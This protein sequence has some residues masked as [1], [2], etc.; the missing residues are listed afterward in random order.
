[1]VAAFHRPCFLC[2]ATL[3][4]AGCLPTGSLRI[5]Q[6]T[7]TGD[8]VGKQEIIRAMPER[9]NVRDAV[10]GREVW[11]A[12]GAVTGV[13][14][15]NAN[16]VATAHHFEDG[17]S[18]LSL[19]LNIEDPREGEFYEAW[20]MS[21]SGGAPISLGHLVF[22]GRKYR[23]TLRY[24]G[25]QDLRNYRRIVVSLEQDD[26]NPAQGQVKAEGFLKVTER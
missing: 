11:F 4:L 23:Q 3:S 8:V 14:G 13:D 10:H 19:V 7:G 1:M 24:R 25:D 17:M 20:L 5:E 16:G 22:G 26:G 2:L 6:P 12:Y 15:T 18:A 9:G 21:E